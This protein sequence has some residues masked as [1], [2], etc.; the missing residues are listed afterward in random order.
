VRPES[1]AP[2]PPSTRKSAT[3]SCYGNDSL[4]M[5]TESRLNR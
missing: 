1:A 4:D 3:S 5:L 2:P